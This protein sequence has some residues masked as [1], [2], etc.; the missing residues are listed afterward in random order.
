MIEIR[1]TMSGNSLGLPFCNCIHAPWWMRIV[2]FTM[3]PVFYFLTLVVD[4]Y[5]DILVE[6]KNM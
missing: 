6:K 3:G 2:Y 4:Y 1:D 5:A